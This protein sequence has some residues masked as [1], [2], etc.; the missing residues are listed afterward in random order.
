[1]VKHKLNL[2]PPKLQFLVI[3]V[4]LSMIKSDQLHNH[5]PDRKEISLKLVKVGLDLQILKLN[6][7][8]RR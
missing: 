1:M 7:L 6:Q 4:K 5:Q 3:V 2:F 8:L